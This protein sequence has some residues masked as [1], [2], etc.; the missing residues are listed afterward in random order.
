MVIK[1]LAGTTVAGPTLVGETPVDGIPGLRVTL[2]LPVFTMVKV[3]L[4]H[5]A[6]ARLEMVIVYVIEDSPAESET[7][8]SS[9]LVE[10]GSG[11]LYSQERWLARAYQNWFQ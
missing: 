4:T 7:V 3:M 9:L 8:P 1:S 5:S 2:R 6:G 11:I 10:E